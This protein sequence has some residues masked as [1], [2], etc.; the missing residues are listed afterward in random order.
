MDNVDNSNAKA[1]IEILAQ[2]MDEKSKETTLSD[3]ERD[4]LNCYTEIR[5]LIND[6]LTDSID[7]L[8]YEGKF[9]VLNGA[10]ALMDAVGLY[11]TFPNLIDKYVIG[12]YH[13]NKTQIKSI[14]NHYLRTSVSFFERLMSHAKQ[15]SLS[16]AIPTIITYG[17]EQGQIYAL[18][19]AEKS[20]ALPSVAYQLLEPAGPP[21]IDLSNIIYAYQINSPNVP[22]DRAIIILPTGADAQQAYY[23]TLFQSLDILV[24][25]GNQFGKETPELSW[26][27]KLRQVILTGK[28]G[29]AQET[30]LAGLE[31]K[32]GIQ[33]LYEK[34]L[35]AA[36]ERCASFS[37]NM[38]SGNFCNCIAMEGRLCSVLWYLA[39]EKKA[40]TGR[41][42][43]INPA[44][45]S[46]PGKIKGKTSP[47]KTW[48]KK[49]QGEIKERL[50]V[51][52]QCGKTY[53]LAM[54]EI[55]SRLDKLQKI[56]GVDEHITQIN[57]HLNE[58]DCLLEILAAEGA[59]FKLYPD[60]VARDHIREL[61]NVYT[62]AYEDNAPAEVL[63]NKFF[64]TPQAQAHLAA[65]G[66]YETN[67]VLLLKIKLEMYEELGLPLETCAAIIQKLGGATTA[68]EHHL[69]GQAYFQQNNQA[70]AAIELLQALH[71]GDL[72]AGNLLYDI[73]SNVDMVDL[74]NHGVAKAAYQCGSELYKISRKSGDAGKRTEALKYLHI[75]AAQGS[76]A[77]MKEL[78]SIEYEEALRGPVGDRDEMLRSALKYYEEAK[79]QKTQ[80]KEVDE[81]IG[82]ISYE[83]KD[84]QKAREY[85]RKA[86][87]AEACYKL[88]LIYINARGV[89]KDRGTALDFFEKAAGKGHPQAQVEQDKILEEIRKENEKKVVQENTSYS[90]SSYYSGYYTSYYSGW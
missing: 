30:F 38:T 31:R 43:Q 42:A 69:L 62:R 33:F 84:Y 18:N 79:K 54:R 41:L 35:T 29:I 23:K 1:V 80:G 47:I 67:S 68:F 86:D 7:E 76:G 16:E 56:C 52:D 22:K 89:A 6:D 14:C 77:A 78:G 39:D 60:Q 10:N 49:L 81:R 3:A 51:L 37:Q 85:L 61:E 34:S 2:V 57:R 66:Q 9:S 63:V 20:I 70:A 5:Q 21:P 48:M 25:A 44:L 55:L 45:L 82:L 74:A 50:D 72:A 17:E 4:M 28:I 88:G 15:L 83:L 12:F 24:A 87:T 19:M 71:G 27:P 59:F 90:G 36:Y 75:A 11:I 46:G 13:P 64:S 73:D 40:L 32:T 58:Q 65:F 26:E 8:P 53:L